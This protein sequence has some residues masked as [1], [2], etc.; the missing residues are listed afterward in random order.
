MRERPVASE[1]KTVERARRGRGGSGG[2]A[3]SEGCVCA[4]TAGAPAIES[5][6][7][8]NSTPHGAPGRPRGRGYT[9]PPSRCALRSD[10]FRWPTFD[11]K[12]SAT[13][14]QSASSSR[15]GA[16]AVIEAEYRALVSKIDKAAEHGALHRNNAA[17]KKARAA[18][19]RARA[20]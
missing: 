18:S 13:T 2:E 6:S 17:R 9:W 19:I 16:A 20:A 5:G 4:P 11:P 15:T 10:R 7:S 3:G 8:V 14:G 12:K 1:K